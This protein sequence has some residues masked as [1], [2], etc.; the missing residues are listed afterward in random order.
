ME[1]ADNQA[2]YGGHMR[3][4]EAREQDTWGTLVLGNRRRLQMTQ[5]SLAEQLGISVRALSRWE[6]DT[7]KPGTIDLARKAIKI[8][9]IDPDRGLWAA[10]YGGGDIDDEPDPY[11]WIR[12][13]GLDPHSRVVRY[14]LSLDISDELRLASLRRER[15]EMLRDETRRIENVRWVVE[16]D[17]QIHHPA[18]RKA[19]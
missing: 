19:S 16:V 18:E 2:F 14:I 12:D 5:D 15:E 4:V 13:M 6:N 9:G 17:Q 8:L 7:A 3:P 11:A 1:R 10:G